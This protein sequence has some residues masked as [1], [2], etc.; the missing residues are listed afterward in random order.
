[1]KLPVERVFGADVYSFKHYVSED[2]A[3][4]L[5]TIVESADRLRYEATCDRT[6]IVIGDTPDRHCDCLSCAAARNYDR[7]RGEE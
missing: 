2:I 4:R 7:L 3:A 6:H 5:E 1:M